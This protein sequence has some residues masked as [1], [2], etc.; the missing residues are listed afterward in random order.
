[1]M[2]GDQNK[3]HKLTNQHHKF[4]YR[5]CILLLYMTTLSKVQDCAC[6]VVSVT[7]N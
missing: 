1:M 7:E 2:K 3:F 4:F 6:L 5:A